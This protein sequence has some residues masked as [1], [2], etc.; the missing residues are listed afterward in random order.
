MQ[1]TLSEHIVRLEEKIVKVRREPRSPDLA[2][3]E[4]SER[5]TSLLN[6]EEALGLFRRAYFPEVNVQ[7]PANL[8]DRIAS[9]GSAG[10]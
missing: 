7:L 4:R 9:I 6:A 10:P 3:F 5:E 8:K 1:K 2:D